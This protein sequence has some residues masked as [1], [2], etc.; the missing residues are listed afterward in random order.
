[1]IYCVVDWSRL[2]LDSF[3]EN[4]NNRTLC[5]LKGSSEERLAR[6]DLGH[7]IKGEKGKG[8]PKYSPRYPWAVF[9]YSD[10]SY[11]I[12]NFR[13]AINYYFLWFHYHL[14]REQLD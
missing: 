10:R 1:M 11:T 12:V 6:T 7:R 14:H 8:F 5:S 13:Y 9:F 2:D 4:Y 3:V